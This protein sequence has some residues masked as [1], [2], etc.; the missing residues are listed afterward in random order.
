[1]ATTLVLPY[2]ELMSTPQEELL[3]APTATQATLP[4]DL[5]RA[6]PALQDVG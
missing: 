4:E 3:D 5:A 6:A 1:V 2:V